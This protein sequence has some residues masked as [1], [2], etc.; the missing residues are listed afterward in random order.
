MVR[1]INIKS[2]V[3][4]A[5]LTLVTACV[6][7]YNPELP[8]SETG[9]LVVEGSILSDA[10]CRF[11]LSRTTDL[12]RE[13]VYDYIYGTTSEYFISIMANVSVEGEDGTHYE[14]VRAADG[15]YYQVKVGHLNT[16]TRYWLRVEADGEIYTSDPTYPLE[17][18]PIDALTFW[19]NE[20]DH[21]VHIMVTAQKP[22]D[23]EIR[24]YQWDCT[25]Y[26]EIHTPLITKYEYDLSSDNIVQI[27]VPKNQGWCTHSRENL[28]LT[29]SRDFKENQI[30][31]Y[32]IY[33][34]SHQDD[35]LSYLYYTR[36]YQRRISKEEYEY[37]EM[38]EKLS[39]QMGGLFTPMPAEL[40]TNIH[41]QNGDRRAIGYVGVCGP[42][43]QNEIFIPSYKVYFQTTHK[44]RILTPEEK[45]GFMPSGLYAR[46]YR[47]SNYDPRSGETDWAERWCVDCTD[48]LWNAS[49][50]RPDFWPED[51][52]YDP[53]KMTK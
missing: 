33:S 35:R 41:C 13:A 19:Q 45:I 16:R 44:P 12:P 31:E 34:I 52:E 6:E 36:V 39:S 53:P 40:P 27:R 48:P 7:D 14:G 37:I 22:A 26:W 46:G 4:L 24:Y 1:W 29:S 32:P 3:L 8:E 18:E 43:T 15:S 28:A 51:G 38:S 9:L 11:Y 23:N 5:L 17:N 30:K 21:L 47:V 2:G 10:V 25:E 20:E 50:E 42:A 49:L